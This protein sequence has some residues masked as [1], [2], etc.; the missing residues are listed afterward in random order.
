MRA[1]WWFFSPIAAGGVVKFFGLRSLYLSDGIIF[2]IIL[3]MILLTGLAEKRYSAR[4]TL[5]MQVRLS[6]QSTGGT[7]PQQ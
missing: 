5:R 2:G 3:L 7:P 4:R 6:T 1:L